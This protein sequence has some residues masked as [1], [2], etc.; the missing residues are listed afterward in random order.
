MH[1]ARS[2]YPESGPKVVQARGYFLHGDQPMQ[3]VMEGLDLQEL[4]PSPSCPQRER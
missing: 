2:R 3:C 1:Q 4:L